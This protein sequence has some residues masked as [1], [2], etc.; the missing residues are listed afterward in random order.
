MLTWHV[1]NRGLEKDA[2]ERI[3]ASQSTSYCLWRAF[4]TY[5]L[6]HHNLQINNKVKAINSI[7]A[8]FYSWLLYEFETSVGY[9]SRKTMFSTTRSS[10]LYNI[11]DIS[12][13]HYQRTTLVCVEFVGN[14]TNSWTIIASG[15]LSTLPKTVYY[16]VKSTTKFWKAG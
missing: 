10:R 11:K 14:G 7:I 12:Q 4:I 5:S 3:C 6:W 1:A 9:G 8:N 13:I 15:K 2:K 16:Q